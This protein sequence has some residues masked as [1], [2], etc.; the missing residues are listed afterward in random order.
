MRCGA[1]AIILISI[2][3]LAC[4]GAVAHAQETRPSGRDAG[5]E[6]LMVLLDVG[7]PDAEIL[8]Y[9]AARGWPAE[10]TRESLAAVFRRPMGATLRAA[11]LARVSEHTATGAL[12]ERFRV[13]DLDKEL[14]VSLLYPRALKPH[15]ET[16]QP[17]S[18]EF[19]DRAQAAW[20]D[21]TRYFAWFFESSGWE[22]SSIAALA[23]VVFDTLVAS[24][25]AQGLHV[26]EPMISACSD[27][28]TKRTFPLLIAHVEA[29]ASSGKGVFVVAL[30]RQPGSTKIA[31]L[32][33]ATGPDVSHSA[34]EPLIDDLAQM[35]AAVRLTR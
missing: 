34:T 19:R 21:G 25:R 27:E 3:A 8:R 23:R 15:V 13:L 12:P 35:L 16:G 10:L 2:A 30:A 28:R 7:V 5:L 33:F 31:V 14:G 18:I 29:A 11:L 4:G 20:F 9:F 24:L 26:A 22:S 6:A 32:G 1:I 17:A